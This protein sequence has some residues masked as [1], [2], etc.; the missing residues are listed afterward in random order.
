MLNRWLGIMTA[1]LM[2]IANAAVFFRDV[3]PG[4]LAGDPPKSAAHGLQPGERL[5]VQVGIF[6][7]EGR[8]LGRSWTEA[9]HTTIGQIRS[10][11]THTL[12]EPMALPQG[13][14][15][16]RVRIVTKITYRAD[17]EHVD[18]L[19]FRI[20]GLSIPIYLR[21]EAMPSGEFPFQ[22]HV[23][24]Q[25]GR[26]I[27]DSRAP[28][29]LGDCIRP[30]DR[31]PDL[32]VGRTWRLDLLDPISQ[33]LPNVDAAGLG[34]DRNILIQVTA[35]EMLDFRGRMVETY[36][37]EG[38]GAKGWV[39]SETGR[40]LRQEVTLPIIGKLVLLDEPYDPTLLQRAI[41]IV[42]NETEIPFTN[43]TPS[44]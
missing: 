42:A 17:Q 27:L 30:F 10:I 19:D 6:D 38:G 36:V 29:A 23:G 34:F 44:Q 31:L 12:L 26:I 41:E 33:I 43:G 5:F 37:V 24:E 35:K 14:V 2:I 11:E 4:W 20:H 15:T 40:V 32:Y 22:W 7:D 18:D 1:T 8:N 13:L 21:A 9:R 39:E 16:P 28:A 3:V 25:E